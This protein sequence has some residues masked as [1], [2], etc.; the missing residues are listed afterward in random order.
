MSPTLVVYSTT[1]RKTE[2]V[3]GGKTYLS[4]SSGAQVLTNRHKVIQSLLAYMTCV[5]AFSYQ[6]FGSGLA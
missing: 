5:M 2:I 1:K 3:V 4:G 6:L